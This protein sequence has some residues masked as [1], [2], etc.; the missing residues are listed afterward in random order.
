MMTAFINLLN[1]F[2]D[3]PFT[4]KFIDLLAGVM[5]VIGIKMKM[6][7]IAPGSMNQKDLLKLIEEKDRQIERLTISNHAHKM[8]Y[9]HLKKQHKGTTCN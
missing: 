5:V 4:L 7:N 3:N 8:R 2:L 9:D 6:N 1:E